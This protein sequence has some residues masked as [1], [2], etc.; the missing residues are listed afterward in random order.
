MKKKRNIAGMVFIV[1]C[2]G[3]LA[4]SCSN[5]SDLPISF[6]QYELDKDGFYQFFTNDSQHYGMSAWEFYE[7]TNEDPNVYQIECKMN[8]GNSVNAFGM[9]FGGSHDDPYNFYAVAISTE[10]YYTAWKNIGSNEED[11]FFEDLIPE[12]VID[13]YGWA[14]AESLNIGYEVLNTITVTKIDA[15]YT[16][17]LNEEEMFTFTDAEFIGN[18]IGFYAT[19]GEEG[20]ESF[21]DTP[22]DARFRQK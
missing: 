13:E 12:A 16:I 7:N 4:A 1:M 8:S 14:E 20:E 17:Y 19:I 11:Y 9:I 22:V 6:V 21:P 3:L 15:S 10:G 5:S 2:I 18:Q